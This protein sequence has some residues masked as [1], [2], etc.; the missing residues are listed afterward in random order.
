[1]KIKE[2]PKG[3][4]LGGLKVKTPKGVIGYWKS[5]WGAGVWL[6]DGKTTRIYPQFVD[7]LEDVLEWDVDVTDKINCDKLTDLKYIDNVQV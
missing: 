4:N 5:Q 6:S 2:L 7:K 3:T 1:M